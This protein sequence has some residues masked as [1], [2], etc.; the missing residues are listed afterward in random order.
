MTKES[1]VWTV[2]NLE[3]IVRRVRSDL[4]VMK[5]YRCEHDEEAEEM[6]EWGLRLIIHELGARVREGEIV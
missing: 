5:G 2:R 6:L 4:D 3:K 1:D